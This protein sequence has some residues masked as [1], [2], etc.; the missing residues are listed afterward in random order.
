VA[1]GFSSFERN[2]YGL[3]MGKPDRFYCHGETD[4][5][6]TIMEESEPSEEGGQEVEKALTRPQGR[7][8][9]LGEKGWQTLS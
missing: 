7:R 4:G 6:Q 9:T 8:Q 5:T 2:S 3:L 1:F